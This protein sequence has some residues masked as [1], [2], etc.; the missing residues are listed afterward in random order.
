MLIQVQVN[1]PLFFISGTNNVV[2][3]IEHF[4][5]SLRLSGLDVKIANMEDPDQTASSEAV[6]SGS[7]L[8]VYAFLAG[9]VFENL[10]QLP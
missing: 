3:K 9:K 1:A 8:F 4:T 6:W 10:D 7:A 5:L 2:L